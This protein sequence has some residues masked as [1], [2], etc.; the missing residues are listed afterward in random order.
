MKTYD[1]YTGAG[2]KLESYQYDG[3]DLNR[4]VFEGLAKMGLSGRLSV[5]TVKMANGEP[6]VVVMA[7]LANGD[8][9]L[10]FHI[11]NKD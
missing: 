8:R 3:S 10:E 5:R 6:I 2:K 1:I 9:V 7:P 4:H 11:E